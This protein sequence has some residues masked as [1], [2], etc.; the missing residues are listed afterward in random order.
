MLSVLSRFAEYVP[1]ALY[2]GHKF[3]QTTTIGNFNDTCSRDY[4]LEPTDPFLWYS[5]RWFMKNLTL[6]LVLTISTLLR[7][8]TRW[9]HHPMILASLQPLTKLF[10]K[11]WWKQPVI[12]HWPSVRH[13]DEPQSGQ[14]NCLWLFHPS[15]DDWGG[16]HWLL[17]IGLRAPLAMVSVLLT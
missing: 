12:R 6:H 8:T 14:S 3:I 17:Q 11:P 7:C 13:T 1:G 9:H 2:P 4:L 15:L 10:I 5:I 16:N